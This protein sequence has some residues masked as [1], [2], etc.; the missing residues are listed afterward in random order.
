MATK[1]LD[2]DVDGPAAQEENVPVP[3]EELGEY[4][5]EGDLAGSLLPGGI[6]AGS[7]VDPL[8]PISGMGLGQSYRER[9]GFPAF[10]TIL[11]PE[12][13]IPSRDYIYPYTRAPNNIDRFRMF[14]PSNIG[15]P[16]LTNLY[17]AY[18][19]VS[20]QTYTAN[21]I[22]VKFWTD[23]PA[24]WA[25]E[26][27]L[28]EAVA[29]YNF[30]V[31]EKPQF[32]GDMKLCPLPSE[33]ERIITLERK[34]EQSIHIPARQNFRLDVAI[35]SWI[36]DEIKK[37]MSEGFRFLWRVVVDGVLTRDVA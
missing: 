8:D 26:Y 15:L 17:N 3:D 23:N 32:H 4:L 35:P 25:K 13:I 20:D 14:G 24:R 18:V 6:F 11:Y 29:L 9:I 37:Q 33:Q 10:D 28:I 34:F 12:P 1:K 7:D 19:F 21:G 36:T 22:Y 2:D 16:E 27:P 30:V 31:G 5:E